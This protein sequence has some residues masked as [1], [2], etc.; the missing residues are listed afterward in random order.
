[1]RK[2]L[3]WLNLL[4]GWWLAPH[5]QITREETM[6]NFGAHAFIWIADWTTQT[7]RT[8]I[9][10]ARK[11]GIDFLEI[12]LLRPAEFDAALT[13]TQLEDNGLRA[14]CSLA[15]P[16][17]AHMPRHPQEAADF[18]H[19]ALDKTAEVGATFLSGVLY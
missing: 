5:D 10:S 2:L 18:L 8:A 9:E 13:R 16:K 11:A 7:G 15:L 6:P 19:L 14:A 3:C 17:D 1:A 4:H 12:P